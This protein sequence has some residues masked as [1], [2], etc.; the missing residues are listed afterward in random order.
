MD[1]EIKTETEVKPKHNIDEI[2]EGI[3]NE[4]EEMDQIYEKLVKSGEDLPKEKENMT[5]DESISYL[6]KNID[7]MLQMLELLRKQR[8]YT[9]TL[10]D[11][12]NKF[13]MKQ[14]II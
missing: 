12:E 13:E 4:L 9:Y 10:S 8:D 14:K 5:L 2:I 11:L 7:Y 6:A 3:K 1:P